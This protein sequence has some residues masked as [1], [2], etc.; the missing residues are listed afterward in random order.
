[1]TL[2]NPPIA[3]RKP[4]VNEAHGVKW[5]DEWHWIRD[6][7]Y[8]DVQDQ[9]VLEYLKAENAYFEAAM[10][11]H[12]ELTDQL[13]EEMKGRIKED[14]STVPIK[15]G[16]WLYIEMSFALVKNAD[17]SLLGSVA[18]ARVAAPPRAAERQ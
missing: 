6:Q 15:D 3:A 12:K 4:H 9:D 10:A 13:F 8:P 17:G 16:S 1:M 5:D 2:Q 11:P 7:N 18:V 14:D